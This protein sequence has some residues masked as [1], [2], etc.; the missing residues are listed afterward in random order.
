MFCYAGW[1][2]WIHPEQMMKTA[3]AETQRKMIEAVADALTEQAE[4]MRKSA[5][6]LSGAGRKA[7]G[8]KR[9]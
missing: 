1:A 3:D 8:R 9:G 5:R 2:S 7:T 6:K 4:L